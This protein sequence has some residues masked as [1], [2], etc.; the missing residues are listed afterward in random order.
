M[1]HP[2]EVIQNARNPATVRVTRRTFEGLPEYNCPSDA[3]C[4]FSPREFGRA[5]MAP[6]RHRYQLAHHVID[7]TSVATL[8]HFH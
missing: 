3:I 1:S 8:A 2:H 5:R 6:A 4:L 7:T